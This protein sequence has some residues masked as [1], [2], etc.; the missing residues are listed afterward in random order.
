MLVIL[1]DIT[2]YGF[3]KRVS[4]A[5]RFRAAA[6]IPV[7]CIPT[8]PPTRAGRKK[9]KPVHNA[10]PDTV[11]AEMTRPTDIDLTDTSPRARLSSASCTARVSSRR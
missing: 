7:I 4:P 2:N 5:R 9:G 1:T 6:V 11:H 8:L 3:I 10:N